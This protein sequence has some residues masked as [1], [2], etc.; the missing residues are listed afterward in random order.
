[1]T[2]AT[3]QATSERG[4]LVD[5]LVRGYQE[6]QSLRQLA[7]ASGRSYG[8]VQGALK[9]A[10][11]TLRTRGRRPSS[12]TA[13]SDAGEAV[14]AVETTSRRLAER[15][16]SALVPPAAGSTQRQAEPPRPTPGKD[17]AM[18]KKDKKADKPKKDKKA[19]K[20]KKDKKAKAK[21]AKKA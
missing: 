16:V 19:D 10:G 4:A 12:P 14:G 17:P 5:Q 11:V 1:M 21:K 2:T 18:A 9:E 8:F 13:T 7:A 3:S 20:P 6:G 15:A